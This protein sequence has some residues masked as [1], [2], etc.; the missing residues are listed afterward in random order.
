MTDRRPRTIRPIGDLFSTRV[1]AFWATTFNA[2]LGLF[3]E[4]LLRRLGDPPLNVVVLMDEQR[5]AK[6][7]SS[8]TAEAV[9]ALSSVNNDWLLRGIKHPGGRFHPKSY[10]AVT[11][12]RAILL[13]GS[14][15]LTLKGLDS[16]REVFT[17]FRS[18]TPT[19]SAALLSWLAW[20]RRIVLDANDTVLAE[21]FW[22]LE[23]QL[24]PLLEEV[25]SVEGPYLVHDLDESLR[26]QFV[27]AIDRS[28]GDIDELTVASPF[29]DA[30]GD[31]VMHL[32]DDLDPSRLS[33][34]V[35][36]TASLDGEAMATN[37]SKR[38]VQVRVFRY[39]PDSFTH[40]KIVSVTSGNRSWV[41]SGSAN[42]SRAG[43]LRPASMG[44]V[45]L[46]VI[47]ESSHS[48]AE[49]IS[50][51]PHARAKDVGLDFLRTLTY[52]DEVEDV[53]TS[54]V[55]LLS[56]TRLPEGQVQV[57]FTPIEPSVHGLT[58]LA[59]SYILDIGPSDHAVTSRSVS[60]NV[61]AIVDIEGTEISNRRFIDNPTQL[62][63][64]LLERDARDNRDRP[65]E[66]D[67]EVGNTILGRWLLELHR[68]L[69][70][71]AT[72][73]TIGS[74]SG[75]GESDTAEETADDGDLWDRLER[76]KLARDPRAHRVSSFRR[77]HGGAPADGI[78][79]L[80]E[81]MGD[82]ASPLGFYDSA[83]SSVLNP[84]PLLE[85]RT[86]EPGNSRR[87][88]MTTRVRVRTRNVLKRWADAQSDPR[89][90]WVDP[91]APVAN[92]VAVTTLLVRL[93]I[94]YAHI[95]EAAEMSFDDLD[96]I[97]FR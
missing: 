48:D 73:A 36:S 97:W 95:D 45:E 23:S 63:K 75:Q 6:S 42:A 22:A 14:G 57:E 91:M 66:F 46:G 19:G 96:E 65:I 10:L 24:E 92:M 49:M 41:L 21:R 33:L 3:C 16:G 71:D 80:L 5:L 8:Y 55:T 79:E 2:D 72:E 51:P 47:H 58:D 31:A 68:T 20:M 62:S 13:V 35:S 87:W 25:A 44:N 43:L 28:N 50:V 56:A 86:A 38:P 67:D 9:G 85:V 84:Q 11:P 64:A 27:E 83:S 70:F 52:A 60:G 30:S 7:L 77:G 32:V 40:A 15:N 26:T 90:L 93:W 34:Y 1:S 4:Y 18:N 89:L 37:L 78:I 53:P 54:A 61:V 94:E 76:E 12:R 39:E 88:P 81:A 29:F 74:T 69:M 59:D 82:Q 17:E